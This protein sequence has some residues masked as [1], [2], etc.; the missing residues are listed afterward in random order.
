MKMATDWC[1][2]TPNHAPGGALRPMTFVLSAVMGPGW[3]GT[4]DS[5][6]PPSRTIEHVGMKRLMAGPLWFLSV[7]YLF[8]LLW[9]LLGVPHFLGPIAAGA[10]GAA[11]WVDP[12][13][14]FWPARPRRSMPSVTQPAVLQTSAK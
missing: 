14:W 4:S 12:M 11:V 9:V 10:V 5:L 1:L 8:E 3:R 7:W 2:G 13:H 6:V